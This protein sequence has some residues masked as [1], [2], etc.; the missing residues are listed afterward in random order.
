MATPTECSPLLRSDNHTTFP[1]LEA[2]NHKVPEPTWPDDVPLAEEPTLGELILVMGPTW[3]GVF[4]AA[5]GMQPGILS[6]LYESAKI[7]FYVRV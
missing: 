4:F 6:H 5:L 3:V 1:G 7:L 2:G